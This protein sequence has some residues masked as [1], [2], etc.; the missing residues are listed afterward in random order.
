MNITWD[1]KKYTQDF[2][3]VHQ[4]GNDVLK[5][6]DF[7]NAGS[8][9]DLG[10]GNGALTKVLAEKGLSVW[11]IDASADQLEIARKN[12]PD[13]SF[14]QADATDFSVDR[15]VDVVFSNAVFHWIDKDKQPQMLECVYKALNKNGQF[16]FECGGFGNNA[17]IHRALEETFKEHGYPYKIPFYFPTIGQYAGMMEKAGFEVK[18]AVLFDRMTELKGENGLKDWL[19]MFIKTPFSLVPDEE[20]KME[21]IDRAV[22]KMKK[23]LYR[24]GKWYSDYVRL[25]MKG[26]RK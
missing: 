21:I 6:I 8:A 19:I 24:E 26:I 2:S 12:Y 13:L 7:E 11:G 17:T 22:E 14:I 9:I 20:E 25:R 5:L 10:C 3:F 16:V 15:P 1:A 4:Y 18:Y 23:D